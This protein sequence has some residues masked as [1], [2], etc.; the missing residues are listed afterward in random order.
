MV[1]M[2]ATMITKP[3]VSTFAKFANSTISS[4]CLFSCNN[5]S[6]TGKIFVSLILVTFTTICRPNSSSYKI[7]GNGLRTFDI[8]RFAK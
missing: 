4:P 1:C 5:S 2:N 6:S 7:E 8:L 3:I